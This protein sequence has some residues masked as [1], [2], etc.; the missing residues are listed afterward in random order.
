M[1][2]RID[3][4]PVAGRVLRAVQ[5][6]RTEADVVETKDEAKPAEPL[7][8]QE[9]LL[10]PAQQ[11]MTTRPAISG[12]LAHTHTH[13]CNQPEQILSLPW[14]SGRSGGALTVPGASLGQ[15][16]SRR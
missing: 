7:V 14:Q 4:S 9:P 5:Y 11:G 15:D 2:Q 12:R 10:A 6:A 8:Q 16:D 3:T 1:Q 13:T